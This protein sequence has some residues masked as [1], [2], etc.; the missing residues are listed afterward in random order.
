MKKTKILA[1]GA[2]LIALNIVITRLLSINIFT[3]R[4]GFGF[5]PVAFG[6]IWFGPLWGA[7]LAVIADVSGML[8]SGGMPWPG[9]TL[10]AALY[11][12]TYGL[13]LHKREINFKNLALCVI[14]QAIFIDAHLGAV[15]YNY[16]AGTPFLAALLSRSID[17]L[18]MIPVKII[19]I[20]YVYKFTGDRIKI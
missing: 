14:L 8:L 6:S 12:I 7:I 15:W 16:Y 20:K 10:S 2:L 11:G 1:Y 17:A 4:I 3:V 9:F 19:V 18:C 13:F 5:L